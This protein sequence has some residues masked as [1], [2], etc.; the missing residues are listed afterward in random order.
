MAK[1]HTLIM[2]DGTNSIDL[3]S[4]YQQYGWFL[5]NATL[6]FPTFKGDG[7]W[8]D[9]VTANGRSL[10]YYTLTNANDAY[11]VTLKSTDSDQFNKDL[12]DLRNM[13][14][15]AANYWVNGI[16]SPVWLE[17]R[18]IN[19]GV[20]RYAI[21]KAGQLEGE[22]SHWHQ[23]FFQP[24]CE[25]VMEFTLAIERDN[26][27]K[28]IPGS[29]EPLCTSSTYPIEVVTGTRP[30]ARNGSSA[31]FEIG[32]TSQA[33][34]RNLYLSN[35]SV[36]FGLQM[37]APGDADTYS[38][39][40]QE[41]ATPSMSMV[42]SS[43]FLEYS[44]VFSVSE[45][46]TRVNIPV[47]L[48]GEFVY[49]DM[50][51]DV[52]NE[53]FDIYFNEVLVPPA[54][55]VAGVGTLTIPTAQNWLYAGLGLFG[56]DSP[57]YFEYIRIDSVSRVVGDTRP[58]DAEIVH[59]FD[60][61]SGNSLVNDG[62]FGSGGGGFDY[63]LNFQGGNPSWSTRNLTAEDTIGKD[64]CDS[65]GTLIS[66]V[67]FPIEITHMFSY[68]DSGAGFSANLM[69]ST[70]PYQIIPFDPVTGDYL[71]V[72]S[73]DGK[74]TH[75]N[76]NLNP[77]A[78]VIDD[79]VPNAP[80]LTLWNRWQISRGG[81]VWEDFSPLGGY[82]TTRSLAVPGVGNV[83]GFTGDGSTDE[84][85]TETVN[86]VVAYWL[87]LPFDTDMWAGL[88]NTWVP[89]TQ[90]DWQ[91]YS[92]IN[93]VE[94]EKYDGTNG[95][96]A[97]IRLIAQSLAL[98]QRDNFP[99]LTRINRIACGFRSLDRGGDFVSDISVKDNSIS[100]PALLPDNL[101][102][103]PTFVAN[104]N[105][106]SAPSGWSVKGSVPAD[107][108]DN[109]D[110]A[111]CQ[112]VIADDLARQYA[113][114][115]KIYARVSTVREIS[116]GEYI[117]LTT[118]R[119]T[120]T[121]F[122]GSD[123]NNVDN[124]Q[125]LSKVVGRDVLSVSSGTPFYLYE[126]GT[127]RIPATNSYSNL[128]DITLE[129]GFNQNGDGAEDDAVFL[130]DIILIPTDEY[131]FF[132]EGEAIAN[133]IGATTRNLALGTVIDTD[134]TFDIDMHTRKNLL[135][136]SVSNLQKGTASYEYIDAI[137]PMRQAS[138]ASGYNFRDGITGVWKF[139]SATPIIIPNV[140]NGG[141]LYFCYPDHT[142]A[143]ALEMTM[144]VNPTYHTLGDIDG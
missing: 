76:F 28:Y 66:G 48:R 87:R 27:T 114:I 72:G 131:A 68:D 83:S 125:Q 58:I 119:I 20:T 31:N 35:F 105:H 111:I 94:V 26:W 85:D 122:M 139:D 135:L 82:D 89:P 51:W 130:S 2:T 40:T 3:L 54:Q 55:E 42:Y 140:E 60:E 25:P 107:P 106:N 39:W 73:T 71:Y 70:P 116:A 29:T 80:S 74:F 63:F 109:P 9:P 62:T 7:S 22:N 14:F 33:F 11:E 93:H 10:S 98:R 143:T 49:V 15:Q 128:T 118:G 17:A 129:I 142:Y 123:V 8:S 99:T 30:I 113:G 138:L 47:Q 13:L 5:R 36:S 44:H 12:A 64:V 100:G 104:E 67:S 117:G 78:V 19:E 24:D 23:P 120:A 102:V 137:W 50:L 75:I 108:A 112:W 110:F 115:Y 59:L 96:L 69:D 34:F 32:T 53:R 65:S 41:G 88:T 86:G 127:V 132:T 144:N 136:D 90:V 84:W 124:T 37:V 103:V 18:G 16:D 95:G 79:D 21:I 121:V 4:K 1:L 81:A 134:G 133:T 77:S 52:T 101:T 46:R 92:G 56:F 61:G 97:N 141:K 38:L 6:N 91:V 45:Y 57:Y 43:L 126:V